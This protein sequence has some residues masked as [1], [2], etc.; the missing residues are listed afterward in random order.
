MRRQ[1]ARIC[2]LCQLL[3][4]AGLTL[5]GLGTARGQFT[6]NRDKIKV[7][8]SGYPENIRKGYQI[9]RTKCNACHGLDTSLKPSMSSAQ[10]SF[11]VKRMQAMA[12]SQ[13]NDNQA[14]A[15]I[16]FLNYDEEHRKARSKQIE[17]PSQATAQVS[18]GRELYESQNCSICHRIAGQGGDAGPDLTDVGGR[19]SREQ[20]IK[21]IQEVGSGSSPVMPHSP[22]H[23]TDQQVSSLVDYLASLKGK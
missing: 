2:F 1:A 9:F 11:E 15:I 18:A 14:N 16:A 17:G 5:T 13:I 21:V 12:S 20:L 10:W 19:L 7:D 6:Q 3:L 4:A 23:L 22:P 8:A